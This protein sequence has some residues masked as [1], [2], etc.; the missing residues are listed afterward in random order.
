MRYILRSQRVLLESTIRPADI[1][2]EDDRIAAIKPPTPN[3]AG[4]IADAGNRLIVPGFVDLHSDAVEKEIEPRPGAQFPIRSAIVELDKKLAMAGITTMF[5]AVAFNEEALVGTRGTQTAARLIEEIGALNS[6]LLSV[7]NLIHARYEIT[8]FSSVP[9]LIDLMEK[10]RVHMISLMDHSPGQ[11]QFKSIEKWK[12]YHVPVYDLAEHEVDDI[13]SLQAD[14]KNRCMGYLDEITGCAR[15]HGL[16]IA[17][18]DDDTCEKVDLMAEIGVTV[19]EFPLNIETAGHAKAKNMATGMGAPNVVRGRSQSGNISARNL[20]QES[21][22]D[23]LCSDYHPTSMLQAVYA[24]SAEL[25]IPLASAFS[26][27]T[28]TPAAIAGLIDRGTLTPGKLAD[29]VV[30]EDANI[31][32][33]VTTIKNGQPVYNSSFSIPT[34]Q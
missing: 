30:I 3:A 1:V 25:G 32:K 23:F 19:A 13:L 33:V 28:S 4:Q 6:S 17:S 5:H 29:M 27:I 8:S 10:R 18:H 11:G 31:P 21:C 2:I 26:Y 9:A 14:K 20:I 16:L 34:C 24:M 12:Q 22:C 7:D 15:H